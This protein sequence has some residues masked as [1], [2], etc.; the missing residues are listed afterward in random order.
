MLAPDFVSPDVE[1]QLQSENGI[2]GLGPYPREG[3]EDADLINAGKEKVSLNPGPS[4]FWL[5]RIVWNDSKLP[6][7]SH[8]IGCDASERCW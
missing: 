7:R 8:I 4:V 2:L 3:N 5:R 6:Y 1:V